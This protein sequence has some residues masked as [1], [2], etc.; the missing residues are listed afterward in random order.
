MVAF[1]IIIVGSG[2]AGAA[3]AWR[4]NEQNPG[5]RIACI[6]RGDWTNP[7]DYPSTRLDWEVLKSSSYSPFPSVR[8]AKADYEIDDAGSDI[9][10]ANFNAVGGATILYSGHFP[11]FHPS[12][13]RVRS[14]DGVAEDWPISYKDLASYYA[15]NDHMMSVSGLEGDPA[16]P[17]I[18]GLLPPVPAGAVGRILGPALNRLGWHW[19]P[20]YSAIATRPVRGRAQCINLGPCNTGC[21]QGAKSSVDVTYWPLALKGGVELLTNTTCQKVLAESGRVTGIQVLKQDGTLHTLGAR[22]VILAANAIGT[23]RILLNSA[24]DGHNNG[25][26]NSSGLVGRNLM[27]HPLGYVEA[28]F[29][30]ELD[31]DKGPQGCSIYSHEFYETDD[32]R[33]FVRGYTMHFL[34]GTGPVEAAKAAMDRRELKWGA[35]F[36]ERFRRLYRRKL[37]MA[38]I[39]E[40][41]PRLSNRVSI[42]PGVIDR[43][44]MP[45][46]KVDYRIDDNT[47]KM[48]G[49]GL[50]MGKKLMREAGGRQA[51]A[52]GPVRNSGWHLM[53]TARMGTDPTT[54]VVD[55]RGECHDVMGLHIFD[56]SIFVT[57]SGVNPASTIQ[58]LSLYLSDQ[59]TSRLGGY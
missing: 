33:G 47:R 19:W 55:P 31:T 38:I 32:S 51:M 7:A 22:I 25:L 21:P 40:D 17:P 13:F 58:A 5:L 20:S 59:L 11:R 49:H 27:L 15:L 46:V 39:C 37:S 56:G 3:A 57:G 42:K 12:D 54:S 10:I 44:G 43:D 9:A 29:D 53:G 4:L 8:K 45:A 26:A 2:A 28:K 34:R 30:E 35:G 48:L 16:Y 24:C 1:D 14:L 52:Y 50:S 23:A 6:E 41:L 36:F 18:E